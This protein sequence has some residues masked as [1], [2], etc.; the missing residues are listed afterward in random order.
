MVD[1]EKIVWNEDTYKKFIDDLKK[2]KDDAFIDFSKKLICSKREFIGIRTPIVKIYAKDISKGDKEGFIKFSKKDYYEEI[3]LRGF[4]IANTRSGYEY[5]LPMIDEYID[6]ID[7]WSLCDLFC[8][9]LKIV[10][11]YPDEFWRYVLGCLDS[12]SPWRIRF[13]VVL[14]L[15]YYIV[16][17]Y[18]KKVLSLCDN[19]RYD[20]YYVKM[21]V[22]WLI[23]VSYVKFRDLT[24]EYLKDSHL[25]NFTYNRAIR[26]IIESR[27]VSESEKKNIKRFIRK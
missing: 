3:L 17:Q 9:S 19:I 6:D 21:A 2:Q 20:D 23:S 1:L 15:D 18:I 8:S 14:M 24:I 5:I 4:V 12:Q 7:N 11:K 10:R 26:K 22:A 25:D 13:A 27:R 16:P